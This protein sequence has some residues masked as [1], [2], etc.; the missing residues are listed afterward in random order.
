[1]NQKN[2]KYKDTINFESISD[3]YFFHP[4]SSF[5]ADI[6]Y[7]CRLTPNQVT[8]IS[9]VIR[10]LG[11]YMLFNYSNKI[12]AV[13]FFTGY[14]LDN[15]DG[16][17]ARRYKMYSKFG[18]ALDLVS[19]QVVNILFFIVIYLA[20]QNY[21]KKSFILITFAVIIFYIALIYWYVINEAVLSY[22]K[23]GS[24]NF[25]EAKKKRFKN[26]NNV[27][28]KIYLALNYSSYRIYKLTFPVFNKRKLKNIMKYVKLLGPG[29]IVLLV[30]F[31][32]YFYRPKSIY[33][34]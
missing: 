11:S 25:Y 31:F 26:E 15:V 9:T 7:K 17:M 3:V 5:I 14:L 23:T 12:A 22:E 32:V 2:L 21:N 18:E 20:Y 24:D 27:L 6:L 4:V 10:L 8:I 29:N 28:S 33:E 1:M 34:F 30:S 19:D 16:I 13:C